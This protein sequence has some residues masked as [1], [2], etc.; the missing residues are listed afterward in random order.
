MM[1]ITI[2]ELRQV[3]AE[4]AAK[5]KKKK[6]PAPRGKKGASE[7]DALYTAAEKALDVLTDAVHSKLQER[8]KRRFRMEQYS[9][10]MQVKNSLQSAMLAAEDYGT[11]RPGPGGQSPNERW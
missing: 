3:I 1:Q 7:I 5:K 6:A 9:Q 11:D 10:L 2:G 8:G 4:A